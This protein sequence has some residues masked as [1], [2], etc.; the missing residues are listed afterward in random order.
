L[1]VNS[2]SRRTPAIRSRQITE[3]DL[4]SVADLLVKGFPRR[5]RQYWRRGL[6]HLTE[7]AAPAGSPKYG[8]LIERD[9]LLVGVLLV[10]SSAIRLDGSMAIRCNLSSWY[11]EPAYRGYASLIVPRITNQ[12]DVTYI[13]VSP[14]WHTQPILEAQGFTKYTSGQLV[15]GPIPSNFT[16]NTQ[17]K[18]VD[19]NAYPGSYFESYERDLLLTHA[20]YGCTSLW[21][22]TTER[23]YPFVFRPRFVKGCIPC[24]QLVYCRDIEDLRR[25]AWPIG[26]FLAL[27]GRPL[28]IVDSNGPIPGFVGKYFHGVAPKYFKGP[29]RPRLGDLAYTEIAMFGI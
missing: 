7:H 1:R 3:S 4:N 27:R 19:F 21:C 13:N 11:F 12:K 6:D 14:A 8:Y 29:N 18:I 28:I 2:L 23:A 5:S 25:F 16:D 20:R 22:I 17:P 9:N 10:L 15:I 26:R 24:A